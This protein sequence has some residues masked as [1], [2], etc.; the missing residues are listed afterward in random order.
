MKKISEVLKTA[1]VLALLGFT[2]TASATT[3][4]FAIGY[5][6]KSMG[7]AGAT[8]SNPQDSVVAAVNPAGMALVGERVD[9]S[10][11]FFSPIRE[12]E[13]TTTAL[14]ASFNV[15]AKSRRDLFII[16][17]IGFTQQFKGNDK[18]WWG[19]SIYGN[20]GLNAT[21]DRNL[22]DES[23]V[24]LGAFGAGAAGF[25]CGLPT[26]AD[27]GAAAA[28]M[29]PEGTTTP[30]LV[31]VSLP[32]ASANVGTLGVDLSQAIFAPTLSYE[33][34]EKH[35]L[36]ASLLI[37]VQRF[38]ARGL[39]NFQ[40][41]TSTVANNPAANPSCAFG[42]ADTPSNGLTNNGND[43]SYGAGVRLG[44]I[45]EVHPR[46]TL[47][48][49]AASKVYMSE[50][51]DYDELFAED[52]D[53]DIPANVTAGITVKATPKL[54]ISFDYQRIFY[55]G[56][57][58]I[59]NAGPTL[60]PSIPPG[61]GPLGANNGLGFGWEDVNTYRLAAEYMHNDQWTLRAGVVT[62]D[63]PIPDD[64]VLFNVLAPAVVEKHVTLGFTYSPN[65]SSEWSFAYM[66]AFEEEVKSSQTAFGIPGKIQMYENSVDVSYSLLF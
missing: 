28:A 65:N 24:V 39:G 1:S 61:S 27:C 22:Y 53:L 15:D 4:Y 47:G 48:L 42:V 26:P 21:Y 31:G 37:G 43:W 20:G 8:V 25:P 30:D 32:K 57:N 51:D 11:R 35:S 41:F 33:V 9:L 52:G 23:F 36:G 44:W 63:Q 14:G 16:P 18:L 12:A 10:V 40:C 54:K 29:V 3:G 55:E 7:L 60:G 13:L 56:V 59:S 6:A 17:N 66:H 64:Q 50:F 46:V 34:N 19:L 62:L 58:S 2:S 5:G 45:G 38:S 49:A